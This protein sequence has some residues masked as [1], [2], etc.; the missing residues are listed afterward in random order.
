MYDYYRVRDMIPDKIIYV[1]FGKDERLSINNPDFR[2]N[3]WV[4]AYYDLVEDIRLNETFFRVMVY[5]YNGKFDGNYQ[6]WI[7][8]YLNLAE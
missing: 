4:N 7:Q 3:D 8:N 5:Q 2:Y 1:D 6:W